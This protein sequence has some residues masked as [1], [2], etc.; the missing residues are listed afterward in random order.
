VL[1]NTGAD[2]LHVSTNGTF[3]FA[4][5]LTSG[6]PYNVT[7]ATQP[8]SPTQNCTISH[9]SG[10]VATANVTDV[11][12][13]CVT[14]PLALTS[15]VPASGASDVSR[16]ANFVLTF[17]APLDASKVTTSS[18]TLR[19]PS[20]IVAATAAVSNNMLTVTPTGQL[21]PSA[22]Y[23]LTVST[24]VQ[25][26][27]GEALASPVTLD[28]ATPSIP[29]T[30]LIGRSVT[31]P[32]ATEG[33][34]CTRMLVPSDLYI[35]GFR[36]TAKNA[37]RAM[38]TVSAGSG[39]LGDYAC[40]PGSLDN[41]LIYASGV[42]TDDFTFPAGFG[43]HVAAGQYLNLNLHVVNSGVDPVTELDQILIQAGISADVTSQAEM[44]M[45]GTFLIN[46]PPDGQTHTA[47]GIYHAG[48]QQLLALLPLMQTYGV[49]QKVTRA[50]GADT[51]LDVD[52]DPT[53]QVFHPLSQVQLQTGDTVVIVCS[54]INTG[55]QT[56]NYGEGWSKEN[57][58]S[59]MY[60]APSAGQSV[61]AGSQ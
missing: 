26:T 5:A 18:V 50:A 53:R 55:T 7:V 45:L 52:F 23:T 35:T 58:F 36:T 39:T 29:W 19:G 2:D 37:V 34:L 21:T 9:G 14:V 49:H 54:Y 10:T 13:S 31:M 46:I 4:T 44:V 22:S 15:S 38:L 8:S 41:A 30:A 6:S 28:F 51:I 61:Y 20:G 47:T 17:S 12:L 33:F 3:A 57:C 16:T 43:I 59:G 25:G 42:A 1:R 11:S 24:A 40:G 32:G 60:L 27:G 56:E 48:N